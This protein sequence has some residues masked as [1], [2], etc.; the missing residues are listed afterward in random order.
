VGEG[1]PRAPPDQSGMTWVNSSSPTHARHAHAAEDAR[2][3]SRGR[4]AIR[5]GDSCRHEAA[6]SRSRTSSRTAL[7]PRVHREVTFNKSLLTCFSKTSCSWSCSTHTSRLTPFQRQSVSGKRGRQGFTA[8][9]ARRSVACCASTAA[10]PR[11]PTTTTGALRRLG[12]C[13]TTTRPGTRSSA[14][15]ALRRARRGD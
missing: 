2:P 8:T 12:A 14:R 7:R 1:P 4:S 13:L 11:T 9:T 10:R 15:S 5:A 3:P 6:R